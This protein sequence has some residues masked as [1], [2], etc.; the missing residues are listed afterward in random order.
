MAMGESYRIAATLHA[1][2]QG[3][4]RCWDA[5]HAALTGGADRLV[6]ASR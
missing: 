5:V 3:A 1:A 2:S 6:M 4:R